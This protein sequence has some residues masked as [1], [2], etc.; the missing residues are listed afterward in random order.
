[1]VSQKVFVYMIEI[2]LILI[3]FLVI[4]YFLYQKD[5][6][7][8][9]ET[10]EYRKTYENTIVTVL[11]TVKET[12]DTFYEMAAR[13]ETKHFEQLQ[14]HSDKQNVFYA[15]QVDKFT[16]LLEKKEQEQKNTI[17]QISR[18]DSIETNSIEK[19]EEI[20]DPL[21]ELT[22]AQFANIKNVQFEGEEQIYPIS[23]E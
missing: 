16:E 15:R 5:K 22:P 18:L 4:F 2:L 1:M 19:E 8:R 11:N 3:T 21:R 12:T 6:K 20:E 10:A 23:V 9:A 14:K 13:I 7:D 17:E